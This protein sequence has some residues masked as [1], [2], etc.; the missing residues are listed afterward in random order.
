MTERTKKLLM[1]L[2]GLAISVGFLIY[3]FYKVDFRALGG[4]LKGA[5]YWWLIPNIILIMVT[6]VFRAF[7]WDHM[8]RPIKKISFSRLFSI[9]MIGFMANNVL[10]FRL[11]EFVRAYSLS[12]REHV[13]KSASLAT[14]FVE[15]IVFDLLAL[16]IIFGIVLVISPLQMMPE[17]KMGAI[18]TIITAMV[19]LV[20]AIYLS[21][22]GERESHVLK[23]ILKIFPARSRPTIEAV[24]ARFAT[25]MDFMRDW[26][27]VFWTTFHTFMIWIIMGLSNYFVLLAFG[28]H[29]PLTA[30][31]VI[32]V[33]VSILIMVPASPGFVG[34]YHYGTLLSLGIYGIGKEEALSCALVMHATQYLVITLVGFY[35]LRREHLSL[36][37]IEEKAEGHG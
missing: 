31:F 15:R 14:I 6:M 16:L 19:G 3:L 2:A 32:L 25:G 5:N 10:P 29:L 36:K 28:W 34:V 18:V 21:S 27:C 37:Q 8:V 35:Y 7:R 11:G 1:Q 33:V 4:A 22:R 17:I 9:T 24:V 12:E 13:S 30:S 20:L 23:A 26:R